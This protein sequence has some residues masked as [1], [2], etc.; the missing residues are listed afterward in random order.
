[1]YNE[2]YS[3]FDRIIN[4]NKDKYKTHIRIAINIASRITKG[5]FKEQD[6]LPS[7]TVLA[8]DYDVSNDKM[9]R[10]LQ[11]LSDVG[12][13]S[14]REGYGTIVLSESKAREYLKAVEL[15]E[16]QLE[17]RDKLKGLFDEYEV[18]GKKIEEMS[19]R[20]LMSY[21]NPLPSEQSL[22]T[23]EVE[24]KPHSDKIGKSIYEL[25]FWQQTGVTVAAIRRGQYT[26]I[27]PGPYIRL[28][29]GDAIV[30]VGA[31]DAYTEV[32]HYI[33][34]NEEGNWYV[35]TKRNVTR[36]SEN[37]LEIVAKALGVE[38]SDIH[39]ITVMSKGMTNQSFQLTCKGKKYILRVPGKGTDNLIDR[40]QEAAAYKA[41]ANKG[42]CD[43][44]AYLDVKSGLK[45]TEF[46]NEVRNGDPFS[47]KDLVACISLMK[48]LHEMKLEVDHTFDVFKMIDFYEGLWG[49]QLSIR[50][51]YESTKAD[52]LSLK[53]YVDK[54]K[55]PYCLT[56]LDAVPDNFLFYKQDGEE[57]IQLTDWEYAGMQDPHM[58]IAMFCIYS[59][60]GKEDIDHFIDLYFN[61]EC[62]NE[63]RIKI[64]CYIAMCGLLW[65]N[66]CE[67][68]YHLGVDYSEYARR[69][70]LYA[71]DFY[72]IAK[73]EM[74]KL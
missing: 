17:L 29:E 18:I 62:P 37:N 52:I 46:L 27:S 20:L 2:S 11:I 74:A 58:D 35:P 7:V 55:E 67:Y 71:K 51:D 25:R 43:N 73:E 6:R 5:D 13:L 42:L 60:Y 31:P 50:D 47:E 48:K 21:I 56:H 64:Y 15:R 49:E 12:V 24:V 57:K 16:E 39:N 72:I 40:N 33:N 59:M 30:C 45:V 41:I 69:Q 23:F 38:R 3:F 26:E 66:W 1:M 4:M 61:N 14:R 68:K 10:A 28:R 8:Q 19:Q 36:V 22:P 70:Y 53:E 63:T 54:H 9:R 65:S 32:D 44:P 34:G